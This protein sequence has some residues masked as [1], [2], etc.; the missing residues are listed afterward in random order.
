MEIYRDRRRNSLEEAL[1]LCLGSGLDGIVSDV[2]AV[3]RNPA[4]VAVIKE[5]KLRL[6]TYGGL[7]NTAEVVC[8]QQMM[9][10]DGVIVD[11]VQEISEVVSGFVGVE[12]VDAE[13]GGDDWRPKFSE[14]QMSFLRK[15]VAELVHE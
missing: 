5:A 13:E 9:G 6:L 12:T 14:G 10:I 3:L 8:L 15:L 2:R 11:H 1:R 7:N 4:A